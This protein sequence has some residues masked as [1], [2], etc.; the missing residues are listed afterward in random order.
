MGQKY[1]PKETLPNLIELMERFNCALDQQIAE[2]KKTH[3]GEHFGKVLTHLSNDL[4]FFVESFEIW[5]QELKAGKER[6]L[7]ETLENQLN[8]A[9]DLVTQAARLLTN[10]H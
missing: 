2:Y 9:K 10:I 4:T 3:D 8:E 1:L 7:L 5:N 6:A